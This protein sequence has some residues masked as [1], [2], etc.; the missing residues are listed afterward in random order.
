MFLTPDAD[1]DFHQSTTFPL[2]HQ[3]PGHVVS[4]GQAETQQKDL[5]GQKGTQLSMFTWF[6]AFILQFSSFIFQ[7]LQK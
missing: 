6:L 1:A 3:R 5:K 4:D 7:I 2:E